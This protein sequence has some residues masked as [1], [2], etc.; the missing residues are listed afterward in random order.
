[1]VK[2]PA[3]IKMLAICVFSFVLVGS[4]TFQLDSQTAMATPPPLTTLTGVVPQVVTQKQAHFVSHHLGTDK[5]NLAVVLQ[6]RDQANL[7]AILKQESDP[8][9]PNYGHYLT[10]T[11]ANQLFNPTMQQEQQVSTWL[12]SN[13]LS[14]GGTYSNHLIVDVSGSVS[15]I[16]QLLHITINDYTVQAEG[17]QISFYAPANAPTVPSTVSSMIQT[18]VGLDN[19]TQIVV[20]TSPLYPATNGNPHNAPPYFPQDFANAYNVNPLWNLGDNGTG[21]HIGITLWVVPPS[22]A[23][24]NQFSAVTGATVA[25]VG[26]GHLKVIPV[27]VHSNCSTSNPGTQQV[28]AEAG[29]D[30]EYTSGMAPGAMIDYYEMPTKGNQPIPAGRI[31]ALNKAGSDS[32]ANWQISNSWTVG[33]EQTVEKNDPSFI[34]GVESVLEDNTV[35]GH[36]YYF[37]SGDSGSTCGG[38][39]PSPSY[40]ASSAYVTSVGGTKFEKNINGKYPP[41][42]AWTGSG[43]GFST[44][45][46]EPWWQVGDGYS[47]SGGMRGYPDIAAD[48]DLHS[49]AYICLGS[50][51][52]C[53]EGGGTSLATPL[54][55]G[56]MADV[57][58]YV[59]LQGYP[60]LGFVPP[61]LYELAEEQEG[62]TP[63]HD[64]TSGNN[65]A[66]N[67]RTG[68]DPVTGWGS[69]NLYNI[70]RD[71]TTGKWRIV[72]NQGTN[73]SVGLSGI[74]SIS[75]SN[76]WAVGGSY[77]NSALIEHWD[78]TQWVIVQNPS[79]T[80]AQLFGVTAI[81]SSNIWAVGTDYNT[82]QGEPLI[83]QWNGAQW[84]IVASPTVNGGEL[85]GVT[86]IS[87]NNIW[88]VGTEVINNG[89]SYQ[90]L[91]EHWD[92][93]QWSVMSSP[94]NDSQLFSVS[95][96]SANNIW[97]VGSNIGGSALIEHWDGTQWSIVSSPS[98][99]GGTFNSVTAVSA[100]DVWAVGSYSGASNQE[101]L[102]EQWNGTNWTVIPS[103]SSPQN[104]YFLSGISAI[105]AS[106][107]WAVGSYNINGSGGGTFTEQ[108][109]GTQWTIVPS[110]SP[111]DGNNSPILTGV[112]NASSTTLWA[113]GSYYNNGSLTP[114]IEFYS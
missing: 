43:G 74:V 104:N 37:S 86:A 81:S 114:L 38:V 41:T 25:T 64:I 78:G 105:S 21:E 16:E 55:A 58:Q 24:L 89:S 31:D 26:N 110:P 94:S 23:T 22:D 3:L 59:Q 84:S 56:M 28:Q 91:I 107:V 9:S 10:L 77:K 53:G 34:T 90:T 39:N 4:V 32:N 80:I 47:N 83:E 13:G 11:Q 101:A 76:T 36:N 51:G 72:L 109:N 98:V 106:N 49:G 30:I 54:F 46:S 19:Y 108:W 63:F 75:A 40:P 102:I 87:A 95:G 62:Y 33:C 48:A 92:G 44:L 60:E 88:A 96:I 97:T 65:G 7:Q 112:V 27:C 6:L 8:H 82:S 67:A 66:Y 5:L 20:N 50:N 79:A 52:I 45:F 61:L 85:F 42:E 35:T 2:R 99:N 69:P 113:V 17:K 100:N 57:N 70:A 14:V 18:I 12:Q 1:M 111:S 93:T 29:M 71:I 73:E 68:W 103:P 15:Q